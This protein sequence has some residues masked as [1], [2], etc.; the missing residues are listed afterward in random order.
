[1]DSENRNLRNPSVSR[2]TL[3]GGSIGSAF[4]LAGLNVSARTKLFAL[5]DA[6]EP[7]RVGMTGDGSTLDPA[8]WTNINERHFIPA[9]FDNLVDV[10]EN[11]GLIPGLATGWETSDDGLEWTFTLREGVLFHDGTEFNAEAVAFHVNWVLDETNAQRHRADISMVSSVEAVDA[12]TV[13]F[14]LS[15]PFAPFAA[16]LYES[17]G[18]ISS[19]AALEEFGADYGSN[20]VGTGP[21]KL[22]EWRRDNQLVLEGF[23]DYWQ[24]DL[25]KAPGVTFLPIPDTAVKL[26]NLRSGD[27]DIVDEIAA[28]DADAVDEDEA[29]QLFTLPGSRWPMVRLNNIVAP[30]DNAL[31]RQAFTHAIPRDGIVQAIYFGRAQPAYGPISPIYGEVYDPAI[32]QNGLLY[33]LDLAKEKLNEAG[34]PDGFEFS[35][36]INSAPQ[37]LRMAELIQSSVGSVGIQMEIQQQESAAFTERLRSKVFQAAIGSWTPRPDV[38]GTIYQHFHTD[39]L[40]NWVSYSNPEVDEILD[41]TRNTPLG[42]ERAEL[43][44]QAERIIVNDAPWAFIVFEELCRAA[45]AEVTGHEMTPDTLLHLGN[46]AKE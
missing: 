16:T 38:D 17:V 27:I 23:E 15:Y 10:D 24:D 14:T 2:R 11:L 30:F 5:Q 42:D 34:M 41:Q 37:T 21:F 35:V 18:Y 25:P 7:I 1:M 12:T 20:P 9:M 32:E 45:R 28:A 43:F 46:V 4:A 22:V 44:R 8:N 40:A 31:L 3:V 26:T 19:S 36:D 39:G 29:L 33:D 6:G 13:K